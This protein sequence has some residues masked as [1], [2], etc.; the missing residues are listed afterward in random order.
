MALDGFADAIAYINL[1]HRTDRYAQIRKELGL[2]FDFDIPLVQRIDATYV[3]DN[4]KVGCCQSHIRALQNVALRSRPNG[5]AMI[6]EDDFM[7][8][9]K[10][11][12]KIADRIRSFWRSFPQAHV[13]MLAINPTQVEW[14]EIPGVVHVVRGQS[15]SAY[16]IRASYIPTLVPYFQRAFVKKQHLDLEW[17]PLQQQGGWYGFQ[18]PLGIQRKSY[19][20]IEKAVKFYGV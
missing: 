6:F 7:V 18:P 9:P 20:D 14:T 13:L 11:L 5:F 12:P 17:F 15:A 10:Q 16:M 4:G 19:S 3:S 8:N 2:L 1:G